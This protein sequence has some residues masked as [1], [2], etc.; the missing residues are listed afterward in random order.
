MRRVLMPPLVRTAG[1][2]AAGA[3]AAY[4]AVSRPW[5]LRWGATPSE[6]DG[7]SSTTNV[8]VD[9]SA[10]QPLSYGSPSAAAST[11]SATLTFPR[12][13]FR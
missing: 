9:A 5:Q 11:S 13:R 3:A 12:Y 8:C 6:I 4:V 2:L 1:V 7:S 10:T